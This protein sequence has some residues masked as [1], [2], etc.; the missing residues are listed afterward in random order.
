MHSS[1]PF[2]SC[3]ADFIWW[4]ILSYVSHATMQVVLVLELSTVD[5]A[6]TVAIELLRPRGSRA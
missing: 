5:G 4:R 2:L 1:P 6:I 3:H